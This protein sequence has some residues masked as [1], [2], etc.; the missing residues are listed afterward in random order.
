MEVRIVCQD[1]LVLPFRRAVPDLDAT[2]RINVGDNVFIGMGA[3]ILPGVTI[4]SNS[5]VGAYS[6]VTKDVEDGTVFG[7][8]P[9]CVLKLTSEYLENAKL[10][11][12]LVGHLK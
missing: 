10:E 2:K 8:N 6:V 12:L 1:G 11:P 7:G 5:I 3:C 4:G 9:A